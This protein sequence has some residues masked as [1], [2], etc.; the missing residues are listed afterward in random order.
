MEPHIDRTKFGSITVDG[1]R[2]KSLLCRPLVRHSQFA[3]QQ[4]WPM[5]PDVSSRR[6]PAIHPASLIAE[7]GLRPRAVIAVSPPG[8]RKLTRQ[9][10]SCSNQRGEA[11]PERNVLL[12]PEVMRV[13][14]HG[15]TQGG[16]VLR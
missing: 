15:P 8:T 6:E 5:V 3:N 7:I 1:D 11:L 12:R 16:A 14:R 9:W 4:D 2:L 10:R 13:I